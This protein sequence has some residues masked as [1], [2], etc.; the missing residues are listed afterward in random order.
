MRVLVDTNV[1]LRSAQPSHPLC[2][3]ATHAVSKMIRQRDSVFFCPQNIAEFWNVATRTVDANG[4]GFSLEEALREVENIEMLLTLLPD[5]PA[6][7]IAW[8]ETVSRHK[9]QGVKVHDARLVAIMKVYAV[10]S[11]L[12]FN[13]ADFKRYSEIT[14]IP[15]SS[16]PA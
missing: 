6:I 8:K 7:Y 12:T 5:I 2:L 16:V 10:E 14:A 9:V 4:L 15:P 11:I 3:Q 13:D 1:L